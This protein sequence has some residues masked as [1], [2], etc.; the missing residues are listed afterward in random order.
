MKNHPNDLHEFK[1]LLIEIE[2]KPLNPL[3]RIILYLVLATMVFGTAWL[4]LAK[5][6][7]VVSAQGKVIPSGEIKI[8]KPLESGVVSKIF[9]KESDRVKKGDI[10]IQIDPTVTDASLSSKQD[11]LAVIN[12]D[13]ALLY[14]LINESNLSKDE[15][16][17]LNSSQLNLYNS[18]RQILASTYESNK[19][20]L[21]SA[22]LDIKANESE[23][24]RLSLLLNKEKEAKVRLQKVLDLI[25]KKEYEEVSKN[26]INLK[27]QRDIALYRLKESNKKLEEII[28]ENEKAIK[29]IKSS[30]IET[31]LGKEKEKRELSAQINAILFSNK[32]Q[33]IKSPVDGFVGKLLIH[34]EGGVVSPNDNLISIVP[35]DAPLIIKAN[36]LNKDIGFLKLGQ[37]VAIKIDTFSFQKYGL[38]HGNIIEISKDAIEDEKLGLIYEIKIKPNSLDIKVEGEIKRLEIGMSVIAEVKTGK[39]RVIELFIYPIIKYMD[40]GLSVR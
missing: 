34:T 11:D 36:V 37:E 12:S 32:T 29:T 23:V 21:N 8:L 17:K 24:N 5:V 30:W 39:R 14:A 16:N 18:Q 28:E 10:L 35:S 4:I 33:Q 27:E 1:P 9:V 6:D 15:I 19:A 13:I 26:I 2:D 3:G 20:K 31:S 25:A 38:L 22:K 40:E 7:V